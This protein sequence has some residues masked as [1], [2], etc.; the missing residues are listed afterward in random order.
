MARDRGLRRQMARLRS[1]DLRLR[2]R[3]ARRAAHAGDQARR[4]ELRQ[5]RHGHRSTTSRPIAAQGEG[6]RSADLSSTPCNMRRICRSTSRRSAATS[7]SARPTSSSARTRASCGA[8]T[9]SSASS[10][11]TRCGPASDEPPE[12]FET[13]TQS[14]EGI[15]GICGRDRLFRL[16][17]RDDG[18][19]ATGRATRICRRRRRRCMPR[20][21]CLCDHEMALAWRLIEG[22]KAL[23]GVAIMGITEHNR[24]RRTACRPSPSSPR[25]RRARR[26]Q[27]ASWP[28]RTSSSGTATTMPSRS[29]AGLGL[30]RSAAGSC[31][32]ASP[33]TTPR[34][35]S[36]GCWPSSAD[37]SPAPRRPRRPRPS[38]RSL[39]A[40]PPW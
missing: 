9:T 30:C 12:K 26:H 16:H 1:R 25:G 39:D 32:S 31:A 4:G 37:T 15:A 36:T 20:S 28:T 14:H 10:M 24:A 17:R 19:P 38:R 6:R 22:L 27:P 34:R 29:S 5:Q 33:T 3:R 7:W 18:R 8:G 35:R 11:P 40:A 13:G 23:H 21:I 2:P